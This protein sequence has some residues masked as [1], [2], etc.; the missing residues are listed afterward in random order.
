MIRHIALIK[1]MPVTGD[2]EVAEIFSKLSSLI[3]RLHG[4]HGFTGGRSGSPEQIERD[5]ARLCRLFRQ[6][7]RLDHLSQSRRQTVSTAK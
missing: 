1:F 2:T 7:Q 3:E 6:K 5:T 4:A